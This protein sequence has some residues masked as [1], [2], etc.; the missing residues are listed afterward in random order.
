[1]Q[2]SVTIYLVSQDI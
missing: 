2:Y 1:M